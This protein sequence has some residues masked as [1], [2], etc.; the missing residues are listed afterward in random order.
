VLVI[1]IDLGTQS[2][3]AVVCDENL[4]VRGSHSIAIT[5]NHPEPGWAE[6]DPRSWDA[7]LAPAIA[8]ALAAANAGP[9]DVA[10]IA[11]TGQLDGCVAID[12]QLAPVHPALIWQDRR[13]VAQSNLVEASRIF[14]ITGQVADASHLAPKIA[15]LRER[16]YKAA[17][18]HQPTSYLVARLCGEHV[19]DPPLASTT[20]LAELSS[21][22]WS[23]RLLEAYDLEPALLPRIR[24]TCEVAGTLTDEGATLAGLPVG[25]RVAVGTGDDFSNPLGAGVVAPGSIICAIGTAEVVGALTRSPVLD[26]IAAEPMVETHVYPSCNANKLFFVENPG[27][28]SGGAIRWA[29]R[30]LGLADDRALDALAA[31][32]P[33]GANG[34]T[35]VPALAGAMTP[36]WRPDLRGSLHDLTAAHDRSHIARA[37]LE[38]LAFA[39]KDVADRLVAMKLPI[40]DVLLV[41]GGAKSRVWA[42][43]RADALGLPHRVAANP[44][45][46]PL[47]AAMIAS[48][49]AGIHADLAAAAGLVSTV[50]DEVSPNPDAAAPLAAAYRRYRLLVGHMASLLTKG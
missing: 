36:V 25:T 3:K 33:P 20:M 50:T 35:F 18:F 9:T 49:A 46:S 43:L 48:V 4:V 23:P 12:A 47:G 26:T 17:R 2:L 39:C 14:A 24:P 38:G 30:L 44:D 8:G 10:A 45:T 22:A 42:Q 40:S 28:L 1:G 16:G 37:V 34:V 19:I 29:T 11:I 41:G 27:W 7:A 6:Q 5:T 31:S 21:G 15:W 13:A 32:A